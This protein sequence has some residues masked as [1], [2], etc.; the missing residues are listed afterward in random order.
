V[1]GDAAGWQSEDLQPAGTVNA[2]RA[3]MRLTLTMQAPAPTTDKRF[4][5]VSGWDVHVFGIGLN[6][7][8]FV[9]G[10]AVPLFKD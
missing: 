8:R 3:D 9:K 7:M 5:F 1:L 2:S 6:W 10:M 4:P